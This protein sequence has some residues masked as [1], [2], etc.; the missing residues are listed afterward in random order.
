MEYDTAID[1]VAT[2]K[3][4]SDAPKLRHDDEKGQIADISTDQELH[5]LIPPKLLNW[6]KLMPGEDSGWQIA[7]HTRRKQVT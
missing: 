3:N 4:D 7:R 6:A 5:N 1:K 2:D